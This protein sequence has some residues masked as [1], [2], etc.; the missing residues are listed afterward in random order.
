MIKLIVSVIAAGAT[1]ASVGWGAHVYLTDTLDGYAEKAE[2][3]VASAKVDFVID[4]QVSSIIAEI[5][6]L[7]RKKNKTPE[8]WDQLRWLRKQLE[9][10][11]RVRR[12][13]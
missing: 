10:L 8:E 5:S 6:F 3:Q 13:R 9:E 12:G 2:V 7:E 4:R 11:R 1:V